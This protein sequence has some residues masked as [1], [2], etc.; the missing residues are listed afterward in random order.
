MAILVVEALSVTFFGLLGIW[1]AVARWHWF[2]RL[3][4]VGLIL[5]A[6]LLIPAYEIVLTFAIQILTIVGVVWFVRRPNVV[7]LRFSLGTALLLMVLA[8]VVAG[9]AIRVP[10]LHWFDWLRIIGVG[11]ISA[12]ATLLAFWLVYGK[13]RWRSRVGIGVIGMAVLVLM[14]FAVDCFDY[15]L[16]NGRIGVRWELFFTEFFSAGILLH[17]WLH[18]CLLPIALGMSLMFGV[19]A[20]GRSSQ[21][22]NEPSDNASTARDTSLFLV[23]SLFCLLIA[24]VTLSMA[25]VLWE[26]ATPQPLPIAAFPDPNGYDDLIA[27]GISALPLTTKAKKPAWALSDTEL[28]ARIQTLQPVLD[29]IDLGLSRDSLPD[30]RVMA[31]HGKTRALHAKALEAVNDALW[32][33][34]TRDYRAGTG[35][36][37]LEQ[38]LKILR[39]TQQAFR[40]TGL[41]WT[42]ASGNHQTADFALS[43]LKQDLLKQLEEGQCRIV[44][45]Q[46]YDFDRGRETWSE[47]LR[48]QS[49]LDEHDD[50]N[51]RLQTL[52]AKWTGQDRYNWLRERE[53]RQLALHRSI[54]VAYGIKAYWLSHN[55]TPTDLDLLVP[56]FLP[57]I[58][59][60]P[61]HDGKLKMKLEPSGVSIYSAGLDGDDDGGTPYPKIGP[62]SYD[63]SQGDDVW[64]ISYADL[65][66]TPAAGNQKKND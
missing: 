31:E 8:S 27:A 62:T 9:F 1:A 26:L 53:K 38:A 13:A 37:R 28:G 30:L 66:A 11:L 2:L 17:P 7:R 40:G 32:L 57:A 34:Y 50:W 61:Y 29:R 44:A 49:M 23:R 35:P 39:F 42:T 16:N 19:I 59:D 25:F 3:A 10:Q 18:W 22:I 48:V 56:E 60:D 41:E 12:Y 63:H 21:W 4:M 52:L 65:R 54:I 5:G 43:E 51:T 64:V 47:K 58:P 36:Q 33:R 55:R 24:V 6:P 20:L 45:R 14:R 15:A 46:L